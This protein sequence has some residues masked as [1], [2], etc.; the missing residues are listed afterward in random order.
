MPLSPSKSPSKSPKK[1]AAP[2]TEKQSGQSTSLRSFDR[3]LPMM[4]IRAREAV[5]HRFRP[6]LRSHDITEQQW[7]ILRVLAENK[8]ADMLELSVRCN[9]Q[10]PSL[11]RT[12]PLLIERG[13][14]QRTAHR[15]D[16][17]RVLVSLTARG[18]TLFRTMSAE[19]VR[20]YQQIEED[21]GSTRLNRLYRALDDVM[22]LAQPSEGAAAPD[23]ED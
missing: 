1:S 9:I 20:L 18:R 4:L 22:T 13:L 16:Q 21:L 14:V 8:H 6:L 10:P 23:S 17:R 11:S 7:R 12:I 19:T 5:M 15:G 2:A 3:S